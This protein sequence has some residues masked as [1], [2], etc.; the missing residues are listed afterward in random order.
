MKKL[1]KFLL[2]FA[3]LSS[4]RIYSQG[5]ITTPGGT[6]S[7]SVPAGSTDFSSVLIRARQS[8]NTTINFTSSD[9]TAIQAIQEQAA[10]MGMNV[11]VNP[12]NGSTTSSTPPSSGARAAAG[13][14]GF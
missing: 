4:A 10:Q 11:N 1:I 7:E 14:N 5:E 3:L 2:T 9:P 12:P 8:G 6:F 13:E